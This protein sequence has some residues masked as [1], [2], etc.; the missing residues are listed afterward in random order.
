MSCTEPATIRFG[1]P[2]H[3]HT[4]KKEK[5]E[6]KSTIKT[7]AATFG[8]ATASLLSSQALAQNVAPS[9]QPASGVN[10]STSAS[11]E[12]AN[13]KVAV[14]FYTLALNDKNPEEA[15]KYISGDFRQ[16]SVL[17][18]DGYSGLRKFLAWVRAEQ[19]KLHADITR[20]F[21]DGNYVILDVRMIRHPGDR[22]LAIAE[23]Y[24]V[25]DGK[26]AEHWDRMQEI[27]EKP[28]NENGLF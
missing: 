8:I 9:A 23:I 3:Q 19:P 24:R 10:Q 12:E 4:P 14:N 15:M 6:M 28:K 2:L 20:V 16:H 13:K 11:Q 26:L 7:V 1:A 21:A 5:P 17:V 27:P 18:E 25:Q 22:G